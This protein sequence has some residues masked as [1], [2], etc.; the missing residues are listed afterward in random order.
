M[1]ILITAAAS[2]LA[3]EL[4]RAL[5]AEH[6]VRLTDVVDVPTQWPFANCDLGHDP[7]TDWLVAD[8]DA[9]IHLAELPP[10]YLD[11]Q[12]QSANRLVD[13]YTRRTYN[14]LH[15][16]SEAGVSRCIYASSLDLFANC[17]DDW[18]VNEQW[19]PRPST[20]PPV[21]AQHL[22]EFV[23]REFAREGRL[24][25]TC[26]RL[27][28]IGHIGDNAEQ[29]PDPT[30]LARQDAVHAI[31]CALA[32]PAEP[33]AVYHIQSTFPAARFSTAKAR[34]ALGFAPRRGKAEGTA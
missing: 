4:A 21:L 9:L 27:G 14:L 29:P 30:W 10:S 22:G 2:A 25:I 26:L 8:V 1:N 16:A 32:A 7:P 28:Q 15:A 18:A 33:W 17:A 19:R 24:A 6:S 31:L 20:E 12:A 3:Q 5:A 13:Y 11:A 34:D 23:C